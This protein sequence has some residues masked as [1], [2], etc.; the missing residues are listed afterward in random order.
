MTENPFGGLSI[1]INTIPDSEI[2]GVNTCQYN[3][4]NARC[5]N[6]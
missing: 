5:R 6:V 2:S 4:L 1:S 3:F